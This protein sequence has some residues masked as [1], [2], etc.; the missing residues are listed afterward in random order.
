MNEAQTE[1]D[2]ILEIE[3]PDLN[4]PTMM[5]IKDGM[6][7]IQDVPDHA[8]VM[9]ALRAMGFGYQRVANILQMDKGNVFRICKRY[10]PK[11]LCAITSETRRL[12]TTE[13]LQT[14]AIASLME[15]TQEKLRDSGAKELASIASKCAVTAEKLNLA[16]RSGGDMSNTKVES[17]MNALDAPTE[18]E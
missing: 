13:M 8:V 7:N 11:G 1:M 17:M 6:L 14:T 9:L 5:E 12:L 15:I 4:L 3:I 10:D 16:K 18:L 2:E